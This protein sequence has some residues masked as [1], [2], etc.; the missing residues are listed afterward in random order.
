MLTIHPHQKKF[1]ENAEAGKVYALYAE[2]PY[3]PPRQAYESVRSRHS[4]LLE[5]IKGPDNISRYSFIG[6]G[7]F[8][9]YSVKNG[10]TELDDGKQNSIVRSDSNKISPLKRLKDLFSDYKIVQSENL[11]PFPGGAV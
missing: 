10:I 7:P 11:P 9:I 2:L 8:L 1:V 3:M 4:F 5:S 6:V